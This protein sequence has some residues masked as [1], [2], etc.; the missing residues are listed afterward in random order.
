MKMKTLLFVVTASVLSVSFGYIAEHTAPKKHAAVTR[1]D[2]AT[3]ADALFWTTF[4]AGEYQQIPAALEALT[5]AHL[6][7]TPPTLCPPRI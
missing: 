2:L 3:R 5:G 4:H 1:T 6:Q 7:P